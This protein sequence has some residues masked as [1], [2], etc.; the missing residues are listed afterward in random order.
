M[1]RLATV[2]NTLT[3]AVV[4]SR[5]DRFENWN[6]AAD[7]MRTPVVG[8][9]TVEYAMQPSRLSAGSVLQ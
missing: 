4:A 7:D 8:L 1:I 3:R 6:P 2:R 5:G 9:E